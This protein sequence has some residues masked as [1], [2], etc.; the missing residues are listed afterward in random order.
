MSG[1]GRG[2]GRR[3]P[4]QASGARL[5]LQKAAEECGFNERNL[6][7]LEKQPALYPD[8]EL[9]SSGFPMA[10]MRIQMQQ[11]RQQELKAQKLKEREKLMQQQ[12]QQKNGKVKVK[13]EDKEDN[14]SSS[15]SDS[16]DDDEEQTSGK[17]SKKNSAL[18]AIKTVKL[19]KTTHLLIQKGR[20]I[21]HRMQNSSFYVQP[22][23]DVPDVLRYADMVLTN[24]TTTTTTND[25]KKNNKKKKCM[26]TSVMRNSLGGRTSTKRG[27]YLPEEL[28]I[29]TKVARKQQLQMVKDEDN[30]NSDINKRRRM[31]LG[32]VDSD[33]DDDD[34]NFM[35][36]TQGG[37][38][39]NIGDDDGS[40]GEFEFEEEQEGEVQDYV[41]NHYDSDD[42][43]GLEDGDENVI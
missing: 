18:A 2:R 22:T 39:N 31:N 28:V 37:D 8:I 29:G 19:S 38:R 23:K 27:V 7:N 1:R 43:D 5:Q 10:K 32:L 34:M 21:H 42:Y 40:E 26:I 24:N 41:V 17:R 25:S 13:E 35:D 16:D 9:H 33:D 30:G 3:A 14:N 6:R 4:A 15:G 12:Q 36:P 20:E 11:E